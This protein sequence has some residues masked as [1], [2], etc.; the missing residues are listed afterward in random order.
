[1]RIDNGALKRRVRPTMNAIFPK[2]TKFRTIAD[3]RFRERDCNGCAT[4]APPMIVNPDTGF[5]EAASHRRTLY[6]NREIKVENAS[7]SAAEPAPAGHEGQ[8]QV[9]LPYLGLFEY[10]VGSRTCQVDTAS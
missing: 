4:L 9:V 3:S 6:Q 1:M 8:Y 2:K 10:S 5:Q 7:V